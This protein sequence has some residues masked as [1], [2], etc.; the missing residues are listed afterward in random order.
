MPDSKG[1]S[2]RRFLSG[3]ASTA[4]T[5]CLP[6][7]GAAILTCNSTP[8]LAAQNTSVS[9]S[10]EAV[11]APPVIIVNSGYRLLI[12]SV[13]G[14]IASFQSREKIR[15]AVG[16]HITMRPPHRA[17]TCG[18]PAYGSH[19]GCVTASREHRR[20]SVCGPALVTR[21][22]DAVFGACFASPH[23]GCSVCPAN[24]AQVWTATNFSESSGLAVN[25]TSQIAGKRSGLCREQSKQRLFMP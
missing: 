22:P 19:L 8:A 11:S 7:S 18:F 25:L 21:Q 10:R 3:V 15:I 1:F 16:T 9:V 13:R 23:S 17:G 12:D 14:T 6:P 2:R 5:S 24:Q 4:A 20:L